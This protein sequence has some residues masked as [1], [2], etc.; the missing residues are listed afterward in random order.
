M[1][2]GRGEGG[3]RDVSRDECRTIELELLQELEVLQDYN[4]VMGL[5][6]ELVEKKSI[7]RKKDMKVIK[8]TSLRRAKASTVL[9]P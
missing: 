6:F 3:G 1:G 7:S 5:V 4:N 8:Y 9:P 2:H